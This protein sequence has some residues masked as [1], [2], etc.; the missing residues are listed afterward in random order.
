MT[1]RTCN[2]E[3]AA[4][5]LGKYTKRNFCYEKKETEVE[6]NQKCIHGLEAISTPSPNPNEETVPVKKLS[7]AYY[8]QL[9]KFHEAAR[10]RPYLECVADE[11]DKE[12]AGLGP[13]KQFRLD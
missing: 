6:L 2:K 10:A 8:N 5:Y 13:A 7:S 3:C 12:R 11:I 1:L 9:L 4:Y